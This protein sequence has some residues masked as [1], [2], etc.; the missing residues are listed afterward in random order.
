MITN[1]ADMIVQYD[2][3]IPADKCKEIIEK[4]EYDHRKS[5]GITASD[6]EGHA[7]GTSIKKSTDLWISQ[8]PEWEEYDAYF[9]EVLSPH[10]KKYLTYIKEKLG[11]VVQSKRDKVYSGYQVQR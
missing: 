10:V 9:F 8:W 1:F 11:D 6:T 3:V 2:D 4:F 5:A 7:D